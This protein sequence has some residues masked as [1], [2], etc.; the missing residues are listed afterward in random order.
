MG[1]RTT[2]Q[3]ELEWQRHFTAQKQSG[4]SKSKY[5]RL[6]NLSVDN[7]NYH[8]KKSAGQAAL[9]QA[10]QPNTS[11]SEFISLVVEPPSSNDTSLIELAFQHKEQI[12]SMKVKWTKDELLDFITAWRAS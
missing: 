4:L 6:N 8:L 7:F 3:Q 9:S 2:Q 10:N 11:A 12:L 5:C 1:R